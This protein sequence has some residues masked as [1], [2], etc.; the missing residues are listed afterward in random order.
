ML[1]LLSFALR[2]FL[3]VYYSQNRPGVPQISEGKIY[4][5][6]VM[7]GTHV[8]LTKAEYYEVDVLLPILFIILF[9]GGAILV[10]PRNRNTNK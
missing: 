8:Y 1:A 5:K 3:D 4:A 9:V 10:V 2:V 6:N 7:H